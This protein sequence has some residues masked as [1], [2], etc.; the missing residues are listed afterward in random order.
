VSVSKLTDLSNQRTHFALL[1]FIVSDNLSFFI[2]S[3]FTSPLVCQKE[4]V[5]RLQNSLALTIL[6]AVVSILPTS[7]VA[8]GNCQYNDRAYS[9]GA[10]VCECPKFSGRVIGSNSRNGRIVSRRLVCEQATWQ[11]ST[12]VCVD[13]NFGNSNDLYGA[14]NRFSQ[15]LCPAAIGSG[16]N[17]VI[18]SRQ[19][20]APRRQS[21][22]KKNSDFAEFEKMVR[23]NSKK[24]YSP[25]E[26]LTLY[27]SYKDWLQKGNAQSK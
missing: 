18:V 3:M 20:V 26:L 5:M 21:R 4:N 13:L 12:Q 6:G 14:I 2:N 25:E 9:S 11:P 8:E 15:E 22:I 23:A 24:N 7:A 19:D 16:S 1:D 27:L 17:R 10:T